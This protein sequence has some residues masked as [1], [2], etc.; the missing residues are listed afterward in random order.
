MRDYDDD[1]VPYVVATIDKDLDQIPGDHYDY[2]QHVFYDVNIFDAEMFFWKQCITGD[3]TDN[4]PGCYRVGDGKAA[5]I[6][7]AWSE[8]YDGD[9]FFD[10]DAWR[11]YLWDNIVELYGQVMA[12]NP[13]RYPEG[14]GA[15][16][17]ALE[18][19][20]LVHMMHYDH[21]LWTP[22]GEPD[23]TL[24]EVTRGT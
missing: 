2:R 21:Q 19:A 23:E 4:I 5:K 15:R 8:D 6:L 22:P 17:A 13:D 7:D 1:G 20:R 10:A 12:N 14:M 24:P 16:E 11:R 18:T 9:P 3:S